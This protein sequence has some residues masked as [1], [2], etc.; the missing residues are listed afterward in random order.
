MRAGRSVYDELDGLLREHLSDGTIVELS[1]A[2]P[3]LTRALDD[4][5]GTG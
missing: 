1:R 5:G 4:M 2:F 3:A